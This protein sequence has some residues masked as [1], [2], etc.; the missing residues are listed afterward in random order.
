M[1]T[2]EQEL[3]TLYIASQM[4]LIGLS[5]ITC[6][7]KREK[8]PGLKDYIVD[9]PLV[10][11]TAQASVPKPLTFKLDRTSSVGQR[12]T[13]AV[14]PEPVLRP[15]GRHDGLEKH[16]DGHGAVE[17]QRSSDGSQLVELQLMDDFVVTADHQAVWARMSDG[18]REEATLG[19]FFVNWRIR[20]D[21]MIFLGFAIH[22]KEWAWNDYVDEVCAPG[23]PSEVPSD[24]TWT[25]CI[26][27]EMRSISP[28]KSWCVS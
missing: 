28:T 6:T 1:W 8:V 20:A 4:R 24:R 2:P 7:S 5:S 18:E 27:R 26:R 9:V 15:D 11:I 10:G 23:Q 16:I 14:L 13:N 21:D 17:H 12:G 19:P 22:A 3:A 25:H